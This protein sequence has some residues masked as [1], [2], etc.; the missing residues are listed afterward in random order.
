MQEGGYQPCESKYVL[1][2]LYRSCRQSL[3]I[4][5]TISTVNVLGLLLCLSSS[6]VTLLKSIVSSTK[7]SSRKRPRNC[8]STTKY[9]SNHF[10]I[11]DID[12]ALRTGVDR[13]VLRCIA[14]GKVMCLSLGTVGNWLTR[15]MFNKRIAKLETLDE[16]AD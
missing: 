16:R 2:S 10:S 5:T 11:K 13:L 9:F 15:G 4:S 8:T 3:S 12:A 1:T 6:P 7:R 14:E